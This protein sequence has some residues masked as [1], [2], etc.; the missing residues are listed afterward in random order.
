MYK[1]YWFALLAMTVLSPLG[2]LA[3]G[4][5]WGEWAAED[6]EEMLGYVPQGIERAGEWWQA[7]FPDYSVKFLGEGHIAEMGGYILSAL[8]GSLMVYGLTFILFKMVSNSKKEVRG[9]CE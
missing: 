8:I 2:L 4:T 9:R 6:L 5:A 3:K 1:R 7:L